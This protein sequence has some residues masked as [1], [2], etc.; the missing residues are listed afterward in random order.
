MKSKFGRDLK[1]EER[2]AVIKELKNVDIA[3]NDGKTPLMLLQY[4]DINTNMAILPL[5]LEKGADVNHTD[6][7]GNYSINFKCTEFLL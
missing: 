6:N 2:A 5:F 1:Q 3:R 4:M 7:N